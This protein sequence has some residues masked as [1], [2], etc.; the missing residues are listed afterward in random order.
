[1]NLDNNSLQKRLENATS[2]FKNFITNQGENTLERKLHNI[3]EKEHINYIDF[4]IGYFRITGFNKIANY[5]DGIKEARVLVGINIDRATFEANSRAKNIATLANEQAKIFNDEINEDKYSSI[6]LLVY[7]LSQKDKLHIRVAPN[8]N[9]HA[10]LYIVRDTKEPYEDVVGSVIIGSSNL[11]HN[12][13]IGN[14]EIN[15]QLNRATEIDEAIKIFNILWE[16]SEELTLKDVEESFIPKF[17]NYSKHTNR[18]TPYKLYIKLLIEHF[19]D[20][21]D[22]I[23]DKDIFVPEHY[24]K[25]SYQVEAVNYGIAKLKKHNG[26]FLSD[27]VGLGK[28]VIVA[29]LIKKLESTFK[30]KRVLV[31]IPPAVR[32]QWEDTFKEFS[33]DCCDICSLAKLSSVISSK[34]KMV[35]VD[36][37]HKFKNRESQ[38]YKQLYKICLNKKVI[39][40]SA[41]PQNN[42]PS[43]LYNQ[44]ALFQNVKNSTLPNCKNLQ[45]FFHQKGKEYKDIIKSSKIDEKKLKSLSEEIRDNILRTVM[46][47]RTRYDIQHHDMYKTDIKSQGLTIPEVEEPKEHT[48]QLKGKLAKVFKDTATKISE[49]LE[50]SRF[51]PLSYLTDEAK[52]RYYPNESKNIFEKNP[53]SGIMKTLLIK[54]F[55]SSFSAFKI[56]IERHKKR[57]K[58]F[59]EDFEKDIVYVGEKATYILDYD[60]ERDGDYDD[61]IENAIKIGRVK[62]L[63]RADFKKDFEKDLKADYKIFKELVATWKDIDKD[64]KLDKFKEVLAKDKDKK[65]VIFTESVDTLEYLQKK[66]KSK[67]LD[68][69]KILFITSQ[70]REEKKQ[71]IK[72]NFDA[73]YTK[74]KNDYNIIITTDTLAE[75]INLHRSSIIYNYDIPWNATKMIQRIGRVNRIGTKA[76]RVYIHNF[77]P[78]VD[79]EKVIK[80]SKKAFIKLQSSHTMM[81]E[82]NKIYTKDEEV[83]SVNLFNVYKQES[84]ERDKELDY[85]EELREFRDKNPKE[86][87]KIEELKEELS[88]TR[89][90]QKE[91]AY[92]VLDINGNKSY[93]YVDENSVKPISFIEIAEAFKP[94]VDEVILE[95]NKEEIELFLEKAIDHF[96]KEKKKEQQDRAEQKV[97]RA[98]EQK[99][100]IYLEEWYQNDMIDDEIFYKLEDII[101]NRG[102]ILM[103]KEIIKITSSKKDISKELKKLLLNYKPIEKEEIKLEIK[104]IITELFKGKK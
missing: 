13:L 91:S 49:E 74:Q 79:I 82:D 40:L 16:H 10:K 42:T 98:D 7:L 12:G 93:V 9:I 51:N 18:L 6:D 2:T 68:P 84:Q 102:D 60:E 95:N 19:G 90:S 4:L 99:A 81:G 24:K 25:L 20:R 85:L 77:K 75:G 78:A 57:Y 30:K 70:N 67:D 56:S 29:M 28:T 65:V 92:V 87:K 3:L 55:E 11:T 86:F 72:E 100:L 45:N 14:F 22:F 53:L 64:P 36:E 35:V 32:T 38:R 71:I 88:L 52:N 96:K 34:Y 101:V 94:K 59:I 73:N 17:K 1:M 63:C 33:I 80:L 41:T 15:T 83:S 26:F 5:L 39:L 21:I 48:Y 54:R 44:I 58:K 46:I 61:F 76:S 8:N 62:K 69:K 104:E 37:S 50:Y 43:D 66:L 31:V 103:A 27:V 89:Q 47:R 23:D 97:D